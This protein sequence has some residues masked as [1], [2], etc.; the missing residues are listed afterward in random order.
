[1]SALPALFVER[2]RAILPDEHAAIALESYSAPLET[3][4][5]VQNHLATVKT[6]LSLL[7]ERGIAPT[8][9]PWFGS[10]FTV[11]AEN[12]A[13]VQA[14]EGIH[15]A[16]IYLQNPSSM[17]PPLVLPVPRGG[18]VLDLAA[19]PGSKTL[20]L[21]NLHPDASIAAVEV[22]RDR[23]FRLKA[24]LARAE[25]NNV[26]VFLQD[27]TR[28][29]RYRPNHFDAVLLDAPCSTEGRFRADDPE[30]TRYWSLK[31]IKEMQFKQKALLE[32]A[33]HC[34]KPGGYVV[35]S[36][37][38]L[39]PEEN[40]AVIDHVLNAFP[41]AIKVRPIDLTLP[42]ALSGMR[43]WQDTTFHPDLSLTL[44]IPPSSR[45]EAFYI[46]LLYKSGE[47]GHEIQMNKNHRS[48]K[49]RY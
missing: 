33:V 38:S 29:P 47:T 42:H 28:V 30:T 1:M 34:V 26:Q 11:A 25:V 20:L 21:A 13:D 40:E 22:V 19:A 3:G 45:Y 12:R 24:N 32:A 39:A 15:P 48:G 14:L 35:Y 18:T 7:A 27:G 36:T 41:D 9:L 43:T 2:L 23:F 31:K 10:G 16:A 37:C 5:R 8:P 6:V 46:A 49:R 44:R 17:I 4:F